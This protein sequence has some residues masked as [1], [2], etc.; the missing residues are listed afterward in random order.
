MITPRPPG[1]LRYDSPQSTAVGRHPR[2][3]MRLEEIKRKRFDSRFPRNVATIE[4]E[5]SLL[6]D[7]VENRW[8]F[9]GAMVD[10]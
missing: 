8:M 9:Q 1:R 10:D 6:V 3:L 7:P 2:I 5:V 4:L